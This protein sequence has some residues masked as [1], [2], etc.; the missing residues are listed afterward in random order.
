MNGIDKPGQVETLIT[1]VTQTQGW[2]C[3]WQCLLLQAG[4]F[5]L[6]WRVSSG[7]STSACHSNGF[8]IISLSLYFVSIYPHFKWLIHFISTF[9]CF[10]HH[11][12]ISSWIP[13]FSPSSF[14]SLF[15]LSICLYVACNRCAHL[16][17][18]LLGSSWD[19]DCIAQSC[20][21]NKTAFCVGT[22][23]YN[24]YLT[25]I[26]SHLSS[27]AVTAE[28]SR[29]CICLLCQN[30]VFHSIQ[31]FTWNQTVLMVKIAKVVRVLNILIMFDHIFLDSCCD[32]QDSVVLR[33]K[34]APCGNPCPHRYSCY[35]EDLH[36]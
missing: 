22:I 4:Y 35:Y 1:I 6:G 34:P 24:R 2:E 29:T 8:L 36:V 7:Y 10:S 31:L 17:F 25:A 5:S 11:F 18:V 3:C 13:L 12:S 28:N 32:P 16:K 9:S 23:L 19:N 14:Q 27:K 20:N 33:V 21:Y 26:S 15:F 30:I